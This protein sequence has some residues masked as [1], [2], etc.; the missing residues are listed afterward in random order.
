MKI[1]VLAVSALALVAIAALA[2]RPSRAEINYPWCA[3]SSA[4]GL[5]QP[6][7]HFA[8]LDQCRAFLNGLTG[9]CRPNPRAAAPVETGKRGAR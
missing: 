5:G 7:C 8:T 2:I 3:V 9:D 1:F 6:L 4:N